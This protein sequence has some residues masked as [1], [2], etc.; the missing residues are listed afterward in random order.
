MRGREDDALYGEKADPNPKD[1]I[2]SRKVTFT[3]IPMT[4]LGELAVGMSEGAR[5]YGRH[6]Y[7]AS[8]VLNS[9]YVDAA[10][11]HI[12]AFWEGE[13]TDPDS[14]MHHLS[15]AIASLA[16][17]RDAQICGRAIDDRPPTLAP[18]DWMGRLNEITAELHE[19]YPEPRDPY[20]RVVPSVTFD[21]SNAS[22]PFNK[23]RTGRS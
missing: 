11:R 13:D 15:K 20:I 8:D 22:H 14:G 3:C 18:V 17:I 12:M 5:K 2:G 10:L 4:V 9:V 21:I 7:R 16:V 23:L 19:K 1:S 6:N